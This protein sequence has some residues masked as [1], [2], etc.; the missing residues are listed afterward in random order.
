VQAALNS[1]PFVL[2]LADPST[3]AG[4]ISVTSSNPSGPATTYT[5]TFGGALAGFEFGAM[6][7][8]TS[9]PIISS[10][11]GASESGSTATITT[12]VAHGFGGG[13][14]V[15][16]AN[17]GVA[18]YN[19]TFTITAVTVAGVGGQTVNSFS[20]TAGSTGLAASGNGTAFVPAVTV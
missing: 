6:T 17:V 4:P 9:V 20:Y 1:L 12:A 2:G 11:N 3:G 10:A 7:V 18:G 5:V 14:T 8:N 13:Q 15:T 19:G 16:V